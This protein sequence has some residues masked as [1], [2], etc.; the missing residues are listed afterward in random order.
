MSTNDEWQPIE[1]APKDGTPV[2]IAA[3]DNGMSSQPRHVLVAHW[4]YSFS[5]DGEWLRDEG[6][7]FSQ[8]WPPTHWQP[9]PDPPT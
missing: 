4:S 7:E 9:L 2:L 6:E 8:T 3:H 1:T 5:D